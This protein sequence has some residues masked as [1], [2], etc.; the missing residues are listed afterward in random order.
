ML[1]ILGAESISR[2]L[3]S[4]H[5]GGFSAVCAFLT[6]LAVLTFLAYTRNLLFNNSLQIIFFHQR[7]RFCV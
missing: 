4:L 3:P 1:D 2:A 7:A 5:I 6:D